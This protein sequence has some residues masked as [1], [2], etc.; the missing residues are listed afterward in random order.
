MDRCCSLRGELNFHVCLLRYVFENDRCK[1]RLGLYV[2][3]L[4]NRDSMRKRKH[5]IIVWFF[6][7]QTVEE[8][9]VSLPRFMNFLFFKLFLF[10]IKY[11]LQTIVKVFNPNEEN[12]N[13][14]YPIV[15]FCLHQYKNSIFLYFKNIYHRMVWQIPLNKIIDWKRCLFNFPKSNFPCA[16][17][18][19]GFV[20]Y[21]YFIEFVLKTWDGE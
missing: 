1:V 11:Y 14:H 21:R 9:W 15:N 19:A 4:E 10:L 3:T 6:P 7:M 2:Y 12:W 16:Y 5:E 20:Y 18:F 8:K 13:F 17:I